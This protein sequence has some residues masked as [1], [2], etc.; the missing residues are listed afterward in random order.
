M[1]ERLA[2]ESL[3]HGALRIIWS[4]ES[5]RDPQSEIPPRQRAA[6]L[7]QLHIPIRDIEEILPDFMPL[8]AEDERDNG[9][10]FRAHWLSNQAHA[11][12]VRETIGLPG[13]TFDARAN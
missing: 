13:I 3:A 4:S 12:F 1:N 5:I 9:S 2:A 6:L 11:R 8:V 7:L 10:P